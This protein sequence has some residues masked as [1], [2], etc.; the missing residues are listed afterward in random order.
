MRYVVGSVGI[1][2]ARYVSGS[3][4]FFGGNVC[5]RVRHVLGLSEWRW[6]FV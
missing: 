1:Q 4:V 5:I 3:V 2:E 6:W